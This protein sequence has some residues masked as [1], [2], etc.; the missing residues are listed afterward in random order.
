MWTIDADGGPPRRLTSDPADDNLPSWSHDGALRLLQ[1]R[2]HGD[3]DHLADPSD[4]GA[5]EQ[6]T[7]AGGGRSQEAPD[8]RTLFFQRDVRGG[9]PLLAVPLAGR[10]GAD[11][12]RLRAS[13]R[14]AVAAA[15]IYHLACG[16]D[17]LGAP[18]F[19]LDPA[20]GRDRLLGTLERPG[21]GTH[22]LPRRED[23]PLHEGRSARAA[24]WC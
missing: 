7:R 18:L 13:L 20:T 4:G 14:L 6:V 10:S 5:E 9:S 1:L 11:G 16:G 15:G 17:A 21:A 3:G 19:L 2:P 23:D 12:R 22:G 8:G 24:T